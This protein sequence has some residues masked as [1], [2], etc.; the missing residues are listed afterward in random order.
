MEYGKTS[1]WV[2]PGHPDRSAD[3]IAARLIT[4]IYKEFGPSAHAA[5]E[6]MLA[7]AP[8]RGPV[9]IVGGETS[10]DPEW[11]KK[12][13]FGFAKKALLEC[14][15]DEANQKKFGKGNTAKASDYDF[16][17]ITNKQ[18]PDIA[19]GVGIDKGWNDQGIYFGYAENTNPYEIG[20]S[21]AVARFIGEKL[22]ALRKDKSGTCGT[23]VKTLVS[24][25][26]DETGP[27]KITDITIAIPT[28]LPE[29]EVLKT[30]AD[31][32]TRIAKKYKWILPIDKDV[33]WIINGTGR[34][35][36]H[37]PL[38]DSGLTGR[39]IICSGG[40]S[41]GYA[42]HG[43]GSAIKPPYASDRLL[44]L[45]ARLIAKT[46]VDAKLSKNCTVSLSGAIGQKTLQSLDIE[47]ADL[48]SKKITVIK[49]WV[50]KTFPI[51]SPHALNKLFKTF[52]LN[53]FDKAVFTDLIGGDKKIQPWENTKPFTKTLPA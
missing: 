48:D 44:P 51:I 17:E 3:Q 30:I 12:K 14:G 18:S 39:K 38:A 9:I 10:V 43:G 53:N 4:E 35:V 47:G 28:T 1:E 50:K 6:V 11:M 22:F 24:V 34:Y 49:K 41:G 40:G 25:K 16:I 45:F 46:V 31:Y 26:Y 8:D 2:S 13:G 42:P 37:G 52:E 29:K 23:D 27:K 21:F 7:D 19:R 15:Y 5:L 33:R 32:I 20:Y 36:K